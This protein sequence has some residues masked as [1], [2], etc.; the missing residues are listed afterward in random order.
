[1]EPTLKLQ[2][3]TIFRDAYA[4]NI[5]QDREPDPM[6]DIEISDPAEADHSAANSKTVP[7]PDLNRDGQPDSA[8]TID[9]TGDGQPDGTYNLVRG[10]KGEVLFQH[11]RSEKPVPF[12]DIDGDGIRDGDRVASVFSG[13]RPEIDWSLI[14]FLSA[15]VAIS[16][17]GGLSNTPVSNYTRD[18]GWGMGHH[19][20]AIPSVVG[21]QDLQL[22]HVGTVFHPTQE[23]LPRWK[24]WYKHVVRD[25]TAVWMPACFLGLALPSMLSV[26]FLQRGTEA[27]NWTAAGMTA[28]QVQEAVGGSVHHA[29]LNDLQT[30]ALFRFSARATLYEYRGNGSYGTPAGSE[31]GPW[32]RN[33]NPPVLVE[34]SAPALGEF[35]WFMTLFC[36]FLVLAPSMATSADGVIRRWVD[37]FWTASPGLRQI[38]PRNI[39][40][41]YFT[42]LVCY[43]IF[44]MVML[45]LNEP[46]ALLKIATTIYNFA[47]GF[48]CWHALVVNLVLLPA[49]LRP[50]WFVRI[51]LALAGV[52][53]LVVAYFSAAQTLGWL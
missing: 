8:V 38:K 17:S 1:M 19:V 52:F 11:P 39:R 46:T 44:G 2:F 15:L 45:S 53:F 36:G 26:Q 23:A 20:G 3:G 49:P 32:R 13:E 9:V 42:V 6:V 7:W 43:A 30:G 16:G 24:R 33:D 12:I 28:N 41:V 21:G 4:T 25:Q 29:H 22:S 14:A 51:A 40:Y 5:D 37:V 47:L 18:Q 34:P 50:N 48:S 35:F 31:G 27:D 10:P